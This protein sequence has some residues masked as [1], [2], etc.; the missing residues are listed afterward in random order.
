M[1]QKQVKSDPDGRKAKAL[2]EL[3]STLT[4]D[5][6]SRIDEQRKFDEITPGTPTYR[7][8]LH[9]DGLRAQARMCKS[10]IEKQRWNIRQLQQANDRLKK[11]IL[12]GNIT[13]EVRDGV[14]MTPA[15]VETLI[16]KN[17]WNINSEVLS[18]PMTLAELRGI[19]GHMDVAR[20]IVMTQE[21]FDAYVAEIES[22]VKEA[23]FN[24]FE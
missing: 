1:A 20:R 10:I 4:H 5:E 14:T 2:E 12:S 21:Q 16:W 22:H 23:G 15:E 17:N 6:I 7:M 9:N 8:A 18:I 13:E 3:R 19:V 11:Q 24:L